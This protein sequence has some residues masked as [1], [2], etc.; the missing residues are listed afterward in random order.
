MERFSV[1][2]SGQVSAL[3]ATSI[4]LGFFLLAVPSAAQQSVSNSSTGVV[5]GV[6]VDAMSGAHLEGAMVLLDPEGR[7]TLSDSLG[8]FELNGV[9]AGPQRLIVQQFGYQRRAFTVSVTTRPGVA[10]EVALRPDPWILEGLTAVVDN[11]TTMKQRLRSR[12]RA[13]PY[14]ARAFEQDV[15]VRSASSDVLDFLQWETWVR[16]VPCSGAIIGSICVV[17]RGRVMKPR[18]YIDEIPVFGLDELVTYPTHA[19]YLL[20]VY[21]SGQEIHAYTYQFMERMALRPMAL[22]PVMTW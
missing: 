10:I 3:E 13:V 2:P 1:I 7:G 19:L 9:S 15:L 5:Q 22:L 4:F 6:V 11:V 16:P 18:V 8:A 12:R 14:A 21:S 17:R 20:E